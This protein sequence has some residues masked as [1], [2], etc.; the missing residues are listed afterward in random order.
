MLTHQNL[1]IL[2]FPADQLIRAGTVQKGREMGLPLQNSKHQNHCAYLTWTE[3]LRG[4]IV[5]GEAYP[6]APEPSEG[7]S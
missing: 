2:S 4:E 1:T 3:D 6:M 7:C 5:G